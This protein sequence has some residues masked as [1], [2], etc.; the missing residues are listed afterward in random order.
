MEIASMRGMW[1]RRRAAVLAVLLAAGLLAG[2]KRPSRGAPIRDAGAVP[3]AAIEGRVTDNADRP[4][5]EARVLAFAQSGNAGPAETST[6]AQGGFRLERLAPGNYRVLVEATG[7]PAAER[8]PVAAP[9]AGLAIRLEGEGRSIVGK[10]LADGVAV[11]GARV[12]LSGD[13]GGPTRE[14]TTRANGGF[15]FGGLGEGQFAVRA[16]HGDAASP[17]LRAVDAGDAATA[18]PVRLD[19]RPGRIVS[20]RVLDDAGAGIPG[21]TVRVGAADGQGGDPLPVTAFTDPAGRFATPAL[22][23]GAHRLSATRAGHL[24]RRAPIVTIA[25]PPAPAPAEVTLELV[26]GARVSG[27]VRDGRGGAASGARVRCLASAMEDLTVVAGPLPL[28]AEAAAM[29]SGAGRALGSTRA[30]VTDREGR[31]TIDDLIPGRYRVEIA[32]PGAEP[33]QGEEIVLGPGERR[34]LGM[35]ALRAGVTIGGRVMDAT[36][37]GLEGARVTVA[38][39]E[40]TAGALGLQTST[41]PSGRFELTLPAGKYRVSAT[42][43]G[44]GAAQVAIELGAASAPAPIELRLVR[45]EARLEG[46]I[47]DTGGRPLARARLIA[48]TGEAA[49]SASASV[50]S[51]SADVGGHFSISPLP[52]GELRLE[53]R[54]PDYPVSVETVT[55]GKFATITVPFPGGV[56]GE[57]RARTSGA[58]VAKAR[59]EAVGPNG[60]TATTDVAKAGGFRLLRLVPGRWRLTATAPGYRPGERELDVSAASTLGEASVRDVRVELDPA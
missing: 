30:A 49:A 9:G 33:Y 5:P 10:V 21:I 59:I 25:A 14:T 40:A 53:I 7:F 32:H 23:P 3:A 36:G 22:P 37:A 51:G 42:A 52:A 12:W 24:L 4:V 44:H 50:G 15:A 18:T 46:L 34:D 29:P 43:P 57:V 17:T 16:A 27:R 38:G 56:S 60:A 1:P 55:P 20:G 11:A 54:H 48:F 8:T 13:A 26:R 41:D 6:D 47:R 35:L 39:V 28:A 31:F 19:L 45:A 2:C 58:V